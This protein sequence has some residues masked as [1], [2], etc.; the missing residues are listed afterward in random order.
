MQGNLD[1]T[2]LF[3]TAESVRAATRRMLASVE[4]QPG[5]VANLGHGVIVGTPVQHVR[6]FVDEV[7][8]AGGD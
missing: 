8:K 2:A 5:V 6:A 4:G 7:Q 1:P 3:G